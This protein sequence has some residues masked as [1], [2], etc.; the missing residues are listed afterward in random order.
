MGTT[1]SELAT[2]RRAEKAAERG[3]HQA[4]ERVRHSITWARDAVIAQ[5]NGEVGGRRSKVSGK[6]C[7]GTKTLSNEKK[8][9]LRREATAKGWVSKSAGFTRKRK[10]LQPNRRWKLRRSR[11]GRKIHE[12]QAWRGRLLACRWLRIG[13]GVKRQPRLGHV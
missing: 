6:I 11:G 9:Q 1:L 5:C 13:G 12:W 7:R 3:K 8:E 10:R 4:L 2:I